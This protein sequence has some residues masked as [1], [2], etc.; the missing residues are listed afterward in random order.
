MANFCHGDTL[1]NKLLDFAKLIAVA[2]C[3]V[4]VGVGVSAMS[5]NYVKRRKYS[6]FTSVGI[7]ACFVYLHVVAAA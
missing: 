4:A 3:N 6:Y 5:A 7:V 2:R 1:G